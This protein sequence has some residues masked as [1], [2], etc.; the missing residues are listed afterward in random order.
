MPPKRAAEGDA[1][2]Q[3]KKFRQAIDEMAE[4]FVCPITQ[5]LPVD[6]V[7]AE[8]GRV[9]ERSAVEE[10]LGQQPNEQVKS[11]IT[12]ELMGKKLFPAVQVRN[13]IKGMVKSGA[14]SG[15]KAD[16]WKKRMEEEEKVAEWRRRAEG[17]DAEAMQALASCYLLGKRGLLK[18]KAQAF[19]WYRKAVDLDHAW[20]LV[21]CGLMHGDGS[22]GSRNFGRSI[23]CLAQAAGLG[24]EAACYWLGKSHLSGARGLDMDVKETRRWFGKMQRCSLKDASRPATDNEREEAAKWLRENPA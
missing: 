8:D 10:W 11:P 21:M 24:S 23:A 20:S 9:Y 15:A 4:E 6:P 5:E 2:Q 22:A 13:S 18:D 12:N 14:I 19:A 7:T 3:A 17:G 16:A 1:T